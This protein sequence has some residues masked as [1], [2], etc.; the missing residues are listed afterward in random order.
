METLRFNLRNEAKVRNLG[1]LKQIAKEGV[2]VATLDN[3]PVL[4]P[5]AV[6]FWDAFVFLSERRDWSE[7]GYPRYIPISEIAAF[8]NYQ[9]WDDEWEREQ[10][11]FHVATLDREYV[12]YKADIVRKKA[13]EA[14]R[15]RRNQPQQR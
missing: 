7:S 6:L 4:L 5:Y 14:A 10:L 2:K 9:G 8:A 15:K 11:L 12:S 3:M 13:E 1:W